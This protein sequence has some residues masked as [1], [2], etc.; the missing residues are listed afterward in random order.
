MVQS[1]S[2]FDKSSK[3]LYQLVKSDDTNTVPIVGRT[4]RETKRENKHETN[5]NSTK[6]Y[7]TDDRED[8]SIYGS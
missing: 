4:K 8:E 1:K 6:N 3:L 5:F 7:T 2:S